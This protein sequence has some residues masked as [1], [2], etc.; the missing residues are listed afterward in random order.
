MTKY[1]CID[2]ETTGVESDCNILTAYFIIL[3]NLFNE[4]DSLDLKIKH[5]SYRVYTKALEINKID[6]IKHDKQAKCIIDSRLKLE[7]FLRK[8]FNEK[9]RFIIIGHNVV[10]DI[11]MLKNNNILPLESCIKYFNYTHLDTIIIAQFLKSISIIPENI[12]LSLSSL[13]KFFN[14]KCN[15]LNID[16]HNAEYDIRMTIELFKYMMKIIRKDPV[17]KKRKL[18]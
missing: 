8:H 18:D 4:V 12:G 6:L 2:T 5:D 11:N 17:N 9:E 10:F 1:I 13:I 15:L 3:D 16:L 14:V 7:M